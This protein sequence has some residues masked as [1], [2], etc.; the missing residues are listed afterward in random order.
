MFLDF[1][2]IVGKKTVRKFS[3][4]RWYHVNLNS[5]IKEISDVMIKFEYVAP[6]ERN[7]FQ[8]SKHLVYHCQFRFF[9]K[10]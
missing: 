9:S 2:K 4:I 1:I 3:L 8:A 5:V 10:F 7:L 6:K